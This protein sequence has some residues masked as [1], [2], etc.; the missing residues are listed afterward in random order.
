MSTD[1][2]RQINH[3]IQNMRVV[4]SVFEDH[5]DI[6]EMVEDGRSRN[7]EVNLVREFEN[8]GLKEGHFEIYYTTDLYRE[9]DRNNCL[10]GDE[11][12]T[13]GCVYN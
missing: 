9:N 8:R 6:F 4:A 10:N 1:K 5:H 3:I 12:Q 11:G 2:K 13:V 7:L